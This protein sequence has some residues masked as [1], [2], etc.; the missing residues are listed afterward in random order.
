MLGGFVSKD[1]IA[2][3]DIQA[4]E[5]VQEYEKTG[6]IRV[7]V[8]DNGPIHKSK[9]VQQKWSEWEAQNLYMFFLPVDHM[10]EAIASL[11]QAKIESNLQDDPS[12]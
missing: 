9:V 4:K 12:L 5:A 10:P 7:I 8:Q 6:R 1:Y 2:I 3:M 11:E